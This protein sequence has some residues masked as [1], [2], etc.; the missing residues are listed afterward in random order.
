MEEKMKV[1]ILSA[2]TDDAEVGCGGSIIK[3]LEDGW[4]LLWVAFSVAEDSLP[5]DMPK[6]TLRKEF[7]NVL[8]MLNLKEKNYIIHN[9]KVRH[10]QENRQDVL[11][12]LVR[13]R[14]DFSPDLV[15]GPSLHDYHQDHHVVANE[16]V[17]AFKT[18]ASLIGYELPWNHITFDTNLFVKLNEYHI[19][20]KYELL[21]NYQSQFVQ[22]RNYFSKEY[23]YGIAKV[24]GI[25][26]NADYAE[27]FEVIRWII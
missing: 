11:E 19:R 17:R 10:L 9:F 25:Q 12:E 14:R 27:A 18:S 8:K 20:K 13:I 24:R 23:I 3:F 1:L 21:Q 6:D 22:R 7:L 26:C 5:K 16:A 15:I 4:D 2:H